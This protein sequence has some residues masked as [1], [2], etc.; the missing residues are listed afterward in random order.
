M[1]NHKITLMA[2]IVLV[3]ALFL[4]ACSSEETSV[5]KTTLQAAVSEKIHHWK[6]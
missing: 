1:K 3:A 6:M 4:A 5:A 2:S